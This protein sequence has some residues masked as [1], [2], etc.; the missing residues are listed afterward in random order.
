MPANSPVPPPT[1]LPRE[2][3][4]L[5][6]LI[7]AVPDPLFCKDL[8]G[9]FLL[10]NTANAAAFGLPPEDF[11]GKT[12]T[13]LPGVRDHAG[14]YQVDD[15]RVVRTGE[16]IL[17]RE[18]PYH[19]LDGKRGT[20]L[21]SKF[22]L[23]DADGVIVGLVGI[24]RDITEAKRDRVELEHTKQ[25]LFD[26]V[27]NSPLAVIEW[28]PDFRVE[29]W[30][31]RANAIFG[32]TP[33]EVVGRHFFDWPFIHPDDTARVAEAARRLIEGAEKSNVCANRNFTKSGATVHCVWQNSVLRDSSG[34]VLTVLSLVQD[35]TEQ[36]R[37]EETAQRA[38]SE[39]AAIERKLQEA[40]KLES[41]GVLA[42]GI[43]H[44][45]NNLLTSVL[46]HSSLLR[47]EM[48]PDAAEQG[49]L[50]QIETAA[51][52]AADL[53]KQMLAYAG[54]G[55]FDIRTLDVNA[56]VEETT[57]LLQV[58][59][60]K[61]VALSFDFAPGLPAVCADATQFRQVLMNLVINASEAIGDKPG[62]IAVRTGVA[63][64]E[65]GQIAEIRGA[66]DLAPGDYIFL[67]VEDSGVGISP[68]VQARIFDPFFTTK[69]TGRGLGLAA[70]LGIVRGHRGALTVRSTPGTG[71]RFR[72]LLPQVEN[73]LPAPSKTSASAFSKPSGGARILIIDDEESV[74]H[75]A[76]R[77]LEYLG[78]RTVV[79]PDGE[80]GVAL[81]AEDPAAFTL[82][83]LDLTMP[84]PDGVETLQ[85][86][87]QRCPEVRVVMMSGY[88]EQEFFRR[89]GLDTA[90]DFIQKPFR[91]EELGAAIERC[92][93]N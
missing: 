40:Q 21:T 84:H 78:H 92:R 58:S 89:S 81:Y 77:M 31:G 41:L 46:G 45:F 74:R 88:S 26:H 9:R 37:A 15:Q 69:F 68:E 1:P 32:W 3:D 82:V 35:V 19:R 4:L 80:R 65:T 6:A 29:R 91:V 79:A 73:L 8:A 56:V 62:H 34:R 43:A 48:P 27:Q 70:V 47:S 64:V 23:R 28:Q 12:D 87:R 30:S 5:R 18:E 63:R 24:A 55:R 67:E 59:I 7:D 10:T 14:L 11:I 2:L 50:E 60:S 54:K 38:E 51:M 33:A 57:R 16:P 71:T 90:T 86:L 39:R 93:S 76:Q 44:D 61:H 22:P 85:A 49:S 66:P 53:C 36:V 25:R 52:R 42:G 72:V 20:Y 13:E 83:L 75:T 17:D